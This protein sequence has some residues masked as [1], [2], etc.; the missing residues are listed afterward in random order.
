M[1]TIEIWRAV[2]IGS[3]VVEPGEKYKVGGDSSSAG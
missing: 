1:F 3:D 2:Q